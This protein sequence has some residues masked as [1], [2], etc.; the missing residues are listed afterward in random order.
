MLSL[1]FLSYAGVGKGLP[2]ESSQDPDLTPAG[3]GVGDRVLGG[4]QPEAFWS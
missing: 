1:D 3:N 2:E 4:A